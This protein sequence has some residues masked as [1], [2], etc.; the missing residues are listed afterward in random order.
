MKQHLFYAL[1]FAI[2]VFLSEGF[3]HLIIYFS[4]LRIT[5]TDNSALDILISV[6]FGFLFGLFISW[7]FNLPKRNK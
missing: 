5:F 2:V 1:L 6:I 4:F 7:T 3:K